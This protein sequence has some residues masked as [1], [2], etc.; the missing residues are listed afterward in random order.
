MGVLS[1]CGSLPT[2]R[3]HSK[4]SARSD[5]LVSRHYFRHY[6][7]TI[8]RGMSDITYARKADELTQ[9]ETDGVSERL[10]LAHVHATQGVARALR[11]VDGKLKYVADQIVNAVRPDGKL[12]RWITWGDE[13]ERVALAVHRIVSFEEF[14]GGTRV[15]LIGGEQLNIPV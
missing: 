5:S 15:E 14:A 4:R 7:T 2:S 11:E 10:A 6:G 3:R 1:V 13:G 12:E 9:V 8:R